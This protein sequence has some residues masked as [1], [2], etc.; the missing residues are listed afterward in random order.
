M[1]TRFIAEHGNRRLALGAIRTWRDQGQFAELRTILKGVKTEVQSHW[2]RADMAAANKELSDTGRKARK[3]DS[4]RDTAQAIGRMA[5]Q[6][7]QIKRAAQARTAEVAKLPRISDPVQAV[8]MVAVAERMRTM[9]ASELSARL[10]AGVDPDLETAALALPQVLT[11]IS[12]GLRNATLKARLQREN[13]EAMSELADLDDA[14]SSVEYGLQ[15]AWREVSGDL[16]AETGLEEQTAVFGGDVQAAQTV[17]MRVN[18]RTIE[19]L[20]EREND[21]DAHK[22]RPELAAE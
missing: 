17:L 22:I 15:E 3:A 1:N 16:P 10:L 8:V 6:L 13:P 18:D 14:V 21:P 12:D 9:P 4:A 20:I 7:A 11:G 19:R 2:Q 5:Q